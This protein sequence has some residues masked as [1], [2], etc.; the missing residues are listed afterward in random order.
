MHVRLTHIDPVHPR[1]DRC[2]SHAIALPEQL[3]PKE[4]N[5]YQPCSRTG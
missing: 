2:L 3:E 5:A 1:I 4:L